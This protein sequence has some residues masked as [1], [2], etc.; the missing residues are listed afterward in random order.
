VSNTGGL[1]GEEVV[2]VY[3]RDIE[4]DRPM[5]LKKLAAFRRV[6]VRAGETLGVELEV[7]ARDFAYYD[8]GQAAFVVEPGDFEVQV[9]AS[10]R[11]I[12]LCGIVTWRRTR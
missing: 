10:S 5:P 7:A 2:Q 1:D 9:G 11:D 4:S 12:R 8:E 3:L 6:F